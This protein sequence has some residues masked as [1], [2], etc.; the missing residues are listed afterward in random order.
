[1]TDNIKPDSAAAVEF[2]TRWAEGQQVVLTSIVPDGVTTTRTFASAAEPAMRAW[3]DE[4]QGKENLY[5]HVNPIRRALSSKAAKEDMDRL[6]WLHVDVDPRVGEDHEAE[7][8]RILKMF[9]EAKVPF[10]VIVD[11]GGGYQGFYKLQPEDKLKIAG[12]IAKA[13]ELEAYNIQLERLFGADSCHNV[14]RIMRIPGTINVP[15]ARKIKKGRKPALA[16]VIR[17]DDTTY[18]ISGF[19]PA[20]RVQQ[21]SPGLSG[22]QPRV[23]ITGNVPVVGTEELRAW[24]QDNRKPP[25]SDWLLAMIATGQ[26]PSDETKYPSRSEALFAVCCALVRAEVPPD[27]IYAV[28]TGPNEIASSVREKRDWHTY[29]LRQIERAMEDAVDPMLR[30][31]NE[32]HAVIGDIGGRCRIISEVYDEVMDR[33][34]ISKAAFED[35]RNRYNNRAVQVGTDSQGNPVLKPLGLWWTLHPQRRQYDNIVFAPN[36]DVPNSFNLWKGFNCEAIPGDKHLKFLEHILKNVCSGNEEHYN[37]FIGWLARLVQDPGCPGEVALV[38]RGRRGT[39]KS[40]VLKIVGKLFGRHF[41]QVSDSKHLVGSFNAH[42]RDVVLLFGDEAF[43]AGDKKHES[44]LKTLITE[45]T[46]I[47]EGKGIDAEAAMNFVHLALASNEDWVVPAGLDERRFFVLEVG[48]GQRMNNAYFGELS[49]IMENGGLENLLHYL[50]NYDLKNFEVRKV[51]QT[52]ALQDQKLLSMGVDFQWFQERLME[53]RLLSRQNEWSGRV[54][55][56]SLYDEYIREMTMARRPAYNH[57]RTTF[58]RFLARCCPPNSL[59]S[60]QEMCDVPV[61]NDYGAEVL[62][63]KRAYVYYFPAL[64]I[65]RDYWDKEMG[66]PYDWPKWEGA[67]AELDKVEGPDVPF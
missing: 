61:A 23:Q 34:R 20:V 57:T 62:I 9:E 24:A 6:A 58:A 13:Q 19:T 47:I 25:L 10:T 38:M 17:F 14:D 35:F 4:R 32:K 11:S 31:L 37:Y 2:L 55:K 46:L 56:D 48:D 33:T 16:R 63:K 5:F 29:A 64:D 67:Q 3:I 60:K 40:F 30:E 26:H 59:T 52:R 18:P 43:F 53:G 36:R 65:L 50:L 1:M 66:G 51:P 8:I 28:I 41:L 42:L 27:M 12:N 39:G 15:N 44:V 7:R 45:D 21:S 54:L 49:N 22:G